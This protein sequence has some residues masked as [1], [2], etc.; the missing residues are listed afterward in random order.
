MPDDTPATVPFH[1]IKSTQF[2]V[3]HT[4]GVVGSVAP[5]GLIFV[6]FYSER[7]AIP[8]MMV[9]EITDAGQVGAERLNE[10][11]SKTGI[12]REVE[13]GSTMSIEVAK[14]FITWLQEKIDLVEK[15]RKTAASEKSNDAAVH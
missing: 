4:D 8:Q 10:R 11:V 5:S 13:V 14:A 6:G 1:Y 3:I 7:S 9:H 12:V 15:L 2:R